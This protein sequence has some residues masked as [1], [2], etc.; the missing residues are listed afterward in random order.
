V[1]VVVIVVV[2]VLAVVVRTSGAEV[3]YACAVH[4]QSWVVH[5]GDGL[6]LLDVL[7]RRGVP[8]DL[9]DLLGDDVHPAVDDHQRD[10]DGAW[11]EG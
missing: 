8:Y 10:Q 7:G 6:D 9:L 5:D 11:R 2:L 1:V 4:E 3:V